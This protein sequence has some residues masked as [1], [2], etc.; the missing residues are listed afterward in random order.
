MFRAPDAPI[1]STTEQPTDKKQV[2]SNSR[3]KEKKYDLKNLK[4]WNKEIWC[5]N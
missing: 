4:T 2:K 3:N 5:L 1:S